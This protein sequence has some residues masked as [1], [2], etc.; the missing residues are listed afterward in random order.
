MVALEE[1]EQI[2]APEQTEELTLE[3]A[4]DYAA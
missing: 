2:Q 3:V 4:R 1:L